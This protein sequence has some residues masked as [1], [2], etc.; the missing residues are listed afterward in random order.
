M[1]DFKLLMIKKIKLMLNFKKEK[2]KKKKGGCIFLKKCDCL[3]LF[4]MFI[5]G[6]KIVVV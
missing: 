5:I 3:Y 6:N 2:K 4:I 1:K